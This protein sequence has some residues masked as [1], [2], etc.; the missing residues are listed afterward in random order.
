MKN[1]V[2]RRA[3]AAFA[4]LCLSA[5]AH[6][7]AP[8]RAISTTAGPQSA[9][10][11][12]LPPDVLATCQRISVETA[13]GHIAD[14]A[15][16]A[17]DCLAS[18]SLP[19][20]LR[21]GVLQQLT[22]LE[23]AL[24]DDRAALDTQLAA[25]E[26][27]PKP[28][29]LQLLLASRLYRSNKRNDESLAT[30]NRVRDAHEVAHDMDRVLGM[31]YYQELGSTLAAMGR[32]Q[33]AIDAFTEGIP[34]EPALADVYRRRAIEREATGDTTGARADYV[35][36]ARWE[37]D[38]NI[39]VPTRA[40]LTALGIDPASERRHPFGDTNPLRASAAQQLESARQALKS[41]ATTDAKVEA[42]SNISIFSDGLD[43]N[44]EALTAIDEAIALAPDTTS[45]RQ[46]KV[47][48]L[49][50]LNR[51]DAAIALAAPMRKQAR[52]EAAMSATPSAIYRN[53]VEVSGSAALAYMQQENWADA[54]EALADTARG[55]GAFDQDYMASLYLYVRAR[56]AAAA[57]ANA[58]FE[59]YIRRA[60]QPVFGNYRRSLLLY[61]QGRVT[62]DQ[63]Y[64]QVISIRDPVAIQNA[65]AETWFMAAGYERYVKHN[66]AAARAYA[67]RLND[68]QPYGTNEWMMAK[69]GGV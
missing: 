9:S 19:I 38:R 16:V 18:H 40:K 28:T 25:I 54:I 42:Y 37:I 47:T 22:F 49:V 53:Y 65:L 26:L 6:N 24:H 55:S 33:E 59:D 66:D 7:S 52:D 11:A 46:S 43:R 61:V 67:A 2:S 1:N 5:C 10:S 58:F 62:I 48:T 8:Q 34:L 41:A 27:M 4:A 31:P 45:Y 44:A 56:S 21:V 14:A 32:H 63:V 20:A 29:D 35:Q 64:L 13:A 57:P 51:I 39:D 69:R 60:S 30:L 15:R 12:Y 36:F 50:G 23:M 68:L 3:A 17:N